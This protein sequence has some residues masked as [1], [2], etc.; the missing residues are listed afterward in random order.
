M[1]LVLVLVL[2]AV[3]RLLLV[4]LPLLQRLVIH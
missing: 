2:V 4:L 3:P 1:P